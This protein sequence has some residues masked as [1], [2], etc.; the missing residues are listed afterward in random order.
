VGL[1]GNRSAEDERYLGAIAEGAMREN[2]A[3]DARDEGG[4]GRGA[5]HGAPL[6]FLRMLCGGN[7]EGDLLLEGGQRSGCMLKIMD[8][9]PKIAAAGNRTQGE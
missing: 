3:A 1:Q 5:R 4:V 8:M 9:R 7:N 2:L 6:E